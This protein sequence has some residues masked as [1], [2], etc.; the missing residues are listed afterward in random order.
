MRASIPNIVDFAHQLTRPVR[1][2]KGDDGSFPP[3]QTSLPDRVAAIVLG[4]IADFPLWRS[5]TMS[6]LLVGDGSF[7]VLDGYDRES[8][9]YGLDPIIVDVPE[10]PSDAD[11][12]Q[13]FLRVRERFKTFPFA[14]AETVL[15]DDGV[16]VVVDLTKRPGA[17]E[18]A[19]LT[20]LLGAVSYLLVAHRARFGCQRAANLRQRHWQRAADAKR[21]APRLRRRHPERQRH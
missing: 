1:R 16:N 11:A 20:G 13:A 17:D 7:R 12:G 4:R 21:V 2:A 5:F 10:R 14:D 8:G 19:F 15:G 3:Q 9:L 18:S 6:P